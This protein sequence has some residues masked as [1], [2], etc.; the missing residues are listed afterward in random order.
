MAQGERVIDA[1]VDAGFESPD[2]FRN[3][4]ARILGLPPAQLQKD[5]LLRADWIKT[6][7]GTMIAVCDQSALHL[8]E[9]ADRKALPQELKSCTRLAMVQSG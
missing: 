7:L 5:G 6:P 3:A 9:F 2:A 8:L 1:Q 4:F